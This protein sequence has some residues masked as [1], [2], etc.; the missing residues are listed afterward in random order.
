[1]QS[2]EEIKQQIIEALAPL[3]PEK[4]ILFGSYAHGTANSESDLDLCIVEKEYR[5]HWEEVEKIDRLLDGIRISKD[6]LVTKLDKYNFYKHEFGSV[7]KDIE[8]K[9]IVLWS[10]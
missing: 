6:I 5:N 9:G 8:E 1:M 3:K 4:I 2:I 7:Y 10:S